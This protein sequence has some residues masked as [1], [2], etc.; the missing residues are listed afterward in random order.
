MQIGINP[1]PWHSTTKR[2]FIQ[3]GITSVCRKTM[4]LTCATPGSWLIYAICDN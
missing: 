4:K 3:L 2:N 1:P